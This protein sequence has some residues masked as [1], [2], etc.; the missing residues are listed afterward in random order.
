MSIRRIM[1]GATSTLAMAGGV[2]TTGLAPAVAATPEC[3][4]HCVQIFS[5][6]F[7][8]AADPGS[9]ESVLGG[10]AEAG[11]P[12][13]LSPIS[14]T[15]PAGDMII[16]RAGAVSSFYADGMVSA[17]V[18]E[19]Y[20][21]LTAVQIE[22]AP[23][24]NATDLCAGLATP[25]YQN[26]ALSLQPCSTPGTTVFILYTPGS[27]ATAPNYFPILT[28]STTDF[29]HPFAMTI[30]GNPDHQD[31]LPITVRRLRGTPTDVPENQLWGSTV[32]N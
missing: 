13:G 32:L 17:E 19:H 24:G 25:A 2:V 21:N 14:S 20:G 22:Y 8:T 28:A 5:A 23:E 11:V 7:G 26:Q 9:V 10:V 30:N 29:V 3:G 1:L 16:S 4:P 18:N 6:K 27:P 31:F 12:T 15:D